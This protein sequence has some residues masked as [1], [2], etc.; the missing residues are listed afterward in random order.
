[1]LAGK[2]LGAATEKELEHR[3]GV[4]ESA[5]GQ[6]PGRRLSPAMWGREGRRQGPSRR[7]SDALAIPGA[8][9]WV[10]LSPGKVVCAFPTPGAGPGLET[11]TVQT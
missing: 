7:G 3:T 9:S 10:I 1:M 4:W 2:I 8:V 11:G 6:S 5:R